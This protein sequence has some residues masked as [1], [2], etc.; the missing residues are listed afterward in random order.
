M[1]KLNNQNILNQKHFIPFLKYELKPSQYFCGREKTDLSHMSGRVSM[2][3]G[4]TK[5]KTKRKKEKK[6]A[7]KENNVLKIFKGASQNFVEC[8]YFMDLF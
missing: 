5:R 6:L 4:T 3:E 1:P 2:L 8:F 7:F